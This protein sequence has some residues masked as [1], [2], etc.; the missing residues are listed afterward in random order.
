MTPFP[1]KNGKQNALFTRHWYLGA[2]KSKIVLKKLN[3][4]EESIQMNYATHLRSSNCWHLHHYLIPKNSGIKLFCTLNGNARRR[5]LR[6]CGWERIFS[7]H[8]HLFGMPEEHI[9][10]TY[11]LPSLV[12][13]YLLLEIKDDLGP[14]TRSYTILGLSKLLA[15]LHFLAS[16]SFQR[17]VA[18]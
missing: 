14:S 8:I 15:N 17:T 3:L 1:T 9:I 5:H 13:F 18:S 11:H 16:G 12:I 4:W 2:W 10:Q 7:T 6:E